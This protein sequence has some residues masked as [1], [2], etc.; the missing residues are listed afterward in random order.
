MAMRVLRI[1]RVMIAIGASDD[2]ADEFVEALDD[3]ATKEDVQSLL[4]K[5]LNRILIGQIA[6]AGVIISSVALL[7]QL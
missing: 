3:L 6:I 2:Q 7:T 1:R 4:A 5:Q